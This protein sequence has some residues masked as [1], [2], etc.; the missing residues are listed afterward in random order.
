VYISNLFGLFF[1]YQSHLF[2]NEQ[3][4]THGYAK[5]IDD[6]EYYIL[7]EELEICEQFVELS[8]GEE[9][10]TIESELSTATEECSSA[11]ELAQTGNAKV[12][13]TSLPTNDENEVCVS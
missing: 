2:I 3:L 7:P 6:T 8:T 13:Q 12:L 11:E 5:W 1:L 10:P 4:V 9:E